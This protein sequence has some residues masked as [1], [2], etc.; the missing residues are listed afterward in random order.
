MSWS[1][2]CR[3][4]ERALRRQ[5]AV[6]VSLFMLT[7][8]AAS[9]V[10]A[11]AG[12][13]DSARAAGM[14]LNLKSVDVRDVLASIA[15]SRGLNIVVAPDVEGRVTVNLHDLDVDETLRAVLLVNG[16]TYVRRDGVIYVTR[17]GAT[18]LNGRA[19]IETVTFRLSY[20][21]PKDVAA[22]VKDALSENGKV[23]AYEPTR[24][25]VLQDTPESVDRARAI[26]ASIDVPPRQVLIGARILEIR[27]DDDDSFGVDWNAVMNG[28][29]ASMNAQQYGFSNQPTPGLRGFFATI[30]TKNLGAFLDALQN[31]VHFRA[32]AAPQV[33]ALEGHEAEIIVGG[34]LGFYVTTTTQTSTVQ[35]VE[36]LDIGSLLTL[37]PTVTDDGHMVLD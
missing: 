13:P 29:H 8:F 3:P 33:L 27:L 6:A 2:T 7:G 17:E 19:W 1:L 34:K 26:I 15:Q 20:A 37:T 16:L 18:S 28:A 21:E 14:A 23:T 5:A 22:A 35:S 4:A 36:F 32:L 9:A 25:V 10:L 31:V 24:T 12:T 11:A 30:S